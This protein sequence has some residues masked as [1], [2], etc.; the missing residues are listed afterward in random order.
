MTPDNHIGLDK[1]VH[2]LTATLNPIKSIWDS[3]SRNV[4]ARLNE[5]YMRVPVGS[6]RDMD[7]R[8]RP[9]ITPDHTFS[10][11]SLSST[12]LRDI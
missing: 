7:S 6:M 8:G 10:T 11:V 9:T 4:N 2:K 5:G 3:K 12:D 1:A